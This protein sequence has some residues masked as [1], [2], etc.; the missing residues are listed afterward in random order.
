LCTVKARLARGLTSVAFE[1]E[2]IICKDEY[3]FMCYYRRDTFLSRQYA[4]APRVA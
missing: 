4:Q 1:L 3:H 2:Q